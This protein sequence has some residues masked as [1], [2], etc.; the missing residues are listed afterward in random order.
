MFHHVKL[1]VSDVSHSRDWYQRVLG[2][3]PDLEFVEH[4]TLMGVVLHNPDS[5]LRLALRQDPNRAAA[6]SGFDPIALNVATL[7][8]LR[9]WADRL[10]RLGEPTGGIVR[11]HRGSVLIGLRDPDG[12]EIRFYTKERDEYPIQAE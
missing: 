11:G 5:G 9:S 10:D 1:P 8:D 6:L 2:L 4:G 12:I 7:V 3:K